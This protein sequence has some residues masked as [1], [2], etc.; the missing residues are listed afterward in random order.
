MILYKMYKN[1]QLG[2]NTSI[3]N[4]MCLTTLESGI[5]VDPWINV[6]PGTFDKTINIGRP[7]E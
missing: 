5:D 6:A 4:V 7:F 1:K 2:S 3:K